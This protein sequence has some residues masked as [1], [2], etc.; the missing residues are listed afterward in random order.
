MIRF[1]GKLP[2]ECIIG[3]SGGVDSV[4]ITDFLLRGKKKVSL[5]FFDH[6]TKTSKNARE[7]VVSFANKRNLVIHIGEISRERNKKESLEE[8]WRNE[9]YKFFSSLNSKIILAHH[10]D[11]AVETWI[12]NSLNGNPMTIPY[13]NKKFKII[14]PFLITPKKELIA[15]CVKNNLDWSQDESNEDCR[16]ARNRIRNNIIPECLKINPGLYKTVKKMYLE[17]SYE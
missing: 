16:F 15:W 3:F 17:N 12:F 8:Y 6:G 11:D 4:A 5:A 1:I 13:E 14:R 2:D 10:L 7:F 9:R